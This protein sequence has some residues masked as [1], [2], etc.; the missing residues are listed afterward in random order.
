MKTNEKLQ[1]NVRKLLKEI[2]CGDGFMSVCIYPNSSDY[3]HQI[4][5][6]FCISV[7]PQ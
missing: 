6:V 5:T 3:V 1:K 7:I 2:D 4:L